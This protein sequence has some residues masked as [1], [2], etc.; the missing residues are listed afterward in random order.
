VPARYGMLGHIGAAAA[1]WLVGSADG[2]RLLVISARRDLRETVW[3]TYK[4]IALLDKTNAFKKVDLGL[5]HSSAASD[6][7]GLVMDCLRQDG[8]LPNFLIRN[9]PPGFKVVNKVGS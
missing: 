7:A 5:V 1:P 9:C 6:I 3:R 8:H 2:L 4:V